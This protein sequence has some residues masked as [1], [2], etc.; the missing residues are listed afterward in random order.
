MTQSHHETAKYGHG[1]CGAQ[2]Q[3]WLFWRS[4]TVLFSVATSYSLAGI[5]WCPPVPGSVTHLRHS[6]HHCCCM[7][8]ATA[9]GFAWLLP[10]LD[11]VGFRVRCGIHSELGWAPLDY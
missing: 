11:N 8:S 1:S 10:L 9:S 6:G 3:E 7:E 5:D 4:L 2:N